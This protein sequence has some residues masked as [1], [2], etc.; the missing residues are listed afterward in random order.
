DRK[1]RHTLEVLEE[2]GVSVSVVLSPEHGL[3]GVA[4][5]EEAVPSPERSAEGGPRVVS[6]YGADP[7]SLSPDPATLEGVDCLLIDLV[8]IG[9][10]YYTYVWT[11]LLAARQAVKLGVF[12]LVLDRP[13]PLGADPS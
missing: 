12:T 13:N 2:L 3:E 10:R 6:L 4:Q 9:S 1:G 7:D 8:D 5:A 11:A